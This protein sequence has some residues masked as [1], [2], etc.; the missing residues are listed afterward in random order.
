[1]KER[2]KKEKKETSLPLS[3]FTIN[4]LLIEVSECDYIRKMLNKKS[5]GQGT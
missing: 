1:M 4:E 5:Y 3:N 2:K